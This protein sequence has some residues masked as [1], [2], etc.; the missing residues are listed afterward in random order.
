MTFIEDLIKLKKKGLLDPSLYSKDETWIYL[1]FQALFNRWIKDFYARNPNPIMVTATSIRKLMEKE[2]GFSQSRYV[3][4]L[5][6]RSCRCM[7]FLRSSAPKNIK[8]LVGK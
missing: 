8:K 4:R 7:V 5:N 2:N 3:K 1:H 6:G